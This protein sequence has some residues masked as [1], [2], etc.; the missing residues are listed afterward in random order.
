[1]VATV[2]PSVFKMVSSYAGIKSAYIEVTSMSSADILDLSAHKELY[3]VLVIELFQID[4]TN[5]N[6]PLTFLPDAYNP[7]TT[8]GNKLTLKTGAIS[9]AKVAGIVYWR[10]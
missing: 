7:T 10:Y 2:T 5:G 3:N 4:G 1:M 6:V 8:Y 9:T